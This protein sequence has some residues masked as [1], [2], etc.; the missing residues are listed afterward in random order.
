MAWWFPWQQVVATATTKATSTA[1]LPTP[2]P[3]TSALCPVTSSADR[4]FIP[5][6]CPRSCGCRC[7][8]C[9][10]YAIAP[11]VS[12]FCRCPVARLLVYA[13]TRADT[14]VR[15]L[16]STMHVPSPLDRSDTAVE[17]GCVSRL[18]PLLNAPLPLLSPGIGRGGLLG[19]HCEV[20][21][22]KLR[23]CAVR[24]QCIA[25]QYNSPEWRDSLGIPAPTTLTFAGYFFIALVPHKQSSDFSF[26][27]HEL[28]KSK[29]QNR[30]SLFY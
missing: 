11:R 22:R 12:F 10:L 8:M 28:D 7:V 16:A 24:Q 3:V 26:V 15:V 9:C 21:G 27:C 4:S 14:A 6:A 20:E 17:T 30:K 13:S 19:V 2:Q 18:P 1:D 25:A 29:L 23:Y 5:P